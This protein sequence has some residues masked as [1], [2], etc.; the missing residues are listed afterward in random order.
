MGGGE[1]KEVVVAVV[2]VAVLGRSDSGCMM[3]EPLAEMRKSARERGASKS[4]GLMIGRMKEYVT[5]LCIV[6]PPEILSKT[7]P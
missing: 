6:S 1:E 4:G 5:F 3:A 7:T 2:V